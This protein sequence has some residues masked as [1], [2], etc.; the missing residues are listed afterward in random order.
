MIGDKLAKKLVQV[1]ACYNIIRHTTGPSVDALVSEL[2]LQLATVAGDAGMHKAMDNEVDETHVAREPEAKRRKFDN[3]QVDEELC[4]FLE[5]KS[6]K[7]LGDGSA[8]EELGIAPEKELED[9]T[10][11]EPFEED[12]WVLVGDRLASV[13]RIGYNSYDKQIRPLWP[14]ERMGEWSAGLW[15]QREDVS[16]LK[17]PARF[18]TRCQLQT[19][20]DPPISI[21]KDMAGYLH[22]FDKDGDL[23]ISLG[24]FHGWHGVFSDEAMSLAFDRGPQEGH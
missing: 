23:V 4:T 24:T 3:D 9:I 13:V 10:P 2:E 21:Q 20:R 6:T 8:H 22:K 18:R 19:V 12:H 17:F 11:E 16:V 5:K 1:D 14:Y 15:V 7:G